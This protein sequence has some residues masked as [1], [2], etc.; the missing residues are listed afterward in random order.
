MTVF[1][2]NGL[3]PNSTDRSR[4]GESESLEGGGGSNS[5]SSRSSNSSDC[6][7]GVL[8]TASRL[9]TGGLLV[10]IGDTDL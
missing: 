6:R 9:F 5:K 1:L 2:D 4:S 7:E 8:R 3:D 10:C